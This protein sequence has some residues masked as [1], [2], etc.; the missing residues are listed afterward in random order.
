MRSLLKKYFSVFGFML[1]MSLSL[2]GNDLNVITNSMHQKVNAIMHIL[3]NEDLL[4]CEKDSKIGVISEGMFDYTLMSRLSVGKKIWKKAT[5]EEKADFIRLFEMRMKKSYIEKSHLLT[6]EKVTVHDAVQVKATRIH[7]SV[8]INGKD[9]DTKITYKYYH[10]KNKEWLI[11]DVEIAG[12]SIL[13]TY[14][15]QFAE[16]LRKGDIQEIINQLQATSSS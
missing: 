13:K 15:A 11:Y 10:A 7:L 2:F 8:I 14:R 5:K 3:R 1:V 6:D 9:K 16:V 12:I 4:R